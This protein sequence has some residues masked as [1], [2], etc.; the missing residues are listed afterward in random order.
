MEA[1]GEWGL[2]LFVICLGFVRN[3]RMPGLGFEFS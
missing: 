3:F 2:G 1:D